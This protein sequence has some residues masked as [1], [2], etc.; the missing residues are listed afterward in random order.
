MRTLSSTSLVPFE[1]SAERFDA[2]D[3]FIRSE[4]LS[5]ETVDRVAIRLGLTLVTAQEAEIVGE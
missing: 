1:N 3:L 4:R 5:S 2:D